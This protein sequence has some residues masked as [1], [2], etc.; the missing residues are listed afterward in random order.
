[1]ARSATGLIFAV[2][3]VQAEPT[4]FELAW[5]APAGC[6]SREAIVEATQ[7]RLAGSPRETRPTLVVRGTVTRV[8]DG[9]SVA[10]ATED[11]AGRRVGE[12]E[13]H[14]DGQ[15]CRAV[16]EPTALVLAMIIAARHPADEAP[17][18][19]LAE[20]VTSAPEPTIPESPPS[21]APIPR[22][23]PV[24]SESTRRLVLGA[25]AVASRGAL[26][27]AGVGLALRA[28]YS[29]MPIFLVGL[30]ASFE[31]GG[32]VR[33]GPGEVGFQLAGG[34]GLAGIQVLDTRPLELSLTLGARAGVI[35]TSPVGFRAVE[36]Q[37]RAV[38][39]VGPGALFRV[40]VIPSLFL[41]ALG[42]AEVVVV[43]DRFHVR[44]AEIVYPIHRPALVTG[45][46]SLGIGY[47]FR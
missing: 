44:D 31:I 8:R 22:A 9:F 43:R 17:P 45:R 6:P 19:A 24:A 20:P 27:I 16:T 21:P 11:S 47:E 42:Q 46:F 5:S 25:S 32:S 4:T 13:V 38:L 34:S 39:L 26:P 1:M 12:R 23:R 14:V 40:Q 7:A 2:R 30:E 41:E 28:T 35:R 15:Q 36:N 18:P 29:P 37:T 10:L 33:T 3:T